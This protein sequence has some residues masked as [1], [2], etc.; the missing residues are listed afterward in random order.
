MVQLRSRRLLLNLILSYLACSSAIGQLPTAPVEV[1]SLP[2]TTTPAPP[3]QVESNLVLIPI[4]VLDHDDHSFLGLRKEDFRLFD[5]KTEQR[6]TQ[7]AREDVPVSI[8][9]V[10]DASASMTGKLRKSQE[11][12][13]SFLDTANAADEFFLVQFNDQ[14]QL[15]LDLTKDSDEVRRELR[16]LHL[17]GETALLDAMHFSLGHMRRAHNLR[18]ALIIVS[19]G[20]DNCSRYTLREL[21]N[22]ARE[23]DVQVYA[24]GIFD[25]PDSR[26]RTLEELSGPALLRD[27][28]HQSGGKMFEIKDLAELPNI[29]AKISEALRNQYVLGYSPLKALRDGKY[30]RVEIKLTQPKGAPK[31]KAGWRRGYYAPDSRELVTK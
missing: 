16:F 31:L 23:S 11:A 18:R 10:I 25:R 17:H 3:F 29:A 9:F 19:D 24:M 6:I 30:H 5:N 4:T 21:K 13:A 12:I 22:L 27:I 20:G 2:T 26:L 7:F 14:V 28:A 1:A 8:G 15:R